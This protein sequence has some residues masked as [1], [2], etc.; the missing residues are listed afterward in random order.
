VFEDLATLIFR[1][2][3]WGAEERDAYGNPAGE[4]EL[5]GVF[6]G[7]IWFK[8]CGLILDRAWTP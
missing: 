3:L 5:D 6:W 4:G 7:A 1:K 8:L 2:S